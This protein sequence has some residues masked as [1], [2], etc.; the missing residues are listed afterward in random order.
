VWWIKN[1]GT[2]V[3]MGVSGFL[4][5]LAPHSARVTTV[6]ASQQSPPTGWVSAATSTAIKK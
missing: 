3:T 5:G 4:G 1:R 2:G 6:K